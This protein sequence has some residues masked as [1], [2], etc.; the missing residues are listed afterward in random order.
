M[1]K[2]SLRRRGFLR[3]CALG[4]AGAAV[5]ACQQALP[6]NA[7]QTE[8]A[9]TLSPSPT[10][11]LA[12][13]P[14]PAPQVKVSVA[15]ADQDAWT[16]VKPVK[17]V[18][19]EPHECEG[20]VV[21]VDGREYEA[22][23][24]GD[25]FTAEVRLAEGEN[26][27]SA[28][29]RREGG[30]EVR[31]EPVNFTGRLREVPTAVIQMRLEEGKIILDGGESA[32]FDG[33]PFDGAPSGGSETGEGAAIVDHLWSARAGN[34][35]PLQIEGVQGL[36]GRELTGEVSSPSITVVPPAV[37]GEYY[38]RLR[39]IDQAGQ[40]DS[41]EV[42][43]VVEA[44]QPR[45][46]D[47]ETEG[48]AWAEE[49]VVYGVIPFLFGSPAF[50]A[51]TDRLDDLA[52]LGINTLWLGPINVHPGDDYGY[53]VEDYFDL[54]PAYGTKEDFHRLVQA[55][56]ARGIRVMM[57]FVPNHTSNTH[58][59]FLDAEKN[60]EESPYWDYYDRDAAGQPTHYFEW[61]HLPNLNY[62]NPEVRRMMLE[63]FS[64]WV[65][66][67]DVDGFRVD[68]AWGIQ[69]RYP[70][71]WPEWRRELK[72]IKADLLLL[73]EASAREPDYFENGFDAAYDWTYQIGGWAWRVIWDTY[74]YRLLAYNLTDALTNRPE[75]FHPDARIFRF[76][77]NND[78]G[79]RFIT[80]HGEGVT[81]VATALLLTLP[82]IPLIYTGD[83]YGLE[84]EPYQELT[85]L[86]FQERYP[87]LRA[88]HKK[89]I[90]LRKSLPNLQSRY[91]TQLEH[92][93][94]PQT[95]YGYFRHGAPGGR[96]PAVEAENDSPVLVLLNFSEEPA[97]IV[98]DLPEQFAALAQGG[99]LYDLLND[100][101]VSISASGRQ[102]VS[103]PGWTA[104][105]LAN[106]P[107]G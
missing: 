101:T 37:D 93:P 29:C 61:E 43:F 7:L 56:H 13:S 74:R 35:A 46:P 31:S 45:I 40:E 17:A 75:G 22:Q 68:V 88:Y 44:G 16:W 5:A 39:V 78:T 63:A 55:A 38:L 102:T 86:T 2:A 99:V 105:I 67:F 36:E 47:F 42:Y 96:E 94:V 48:P 106:Q 12:P 80:T 26:Q 60:G 20:V 64:Y 72:R 66:E 53:A 85:P 19:S 4:A 24:E 18:V 103:V 54:D 97:E 32:P 11:T 59:Y 9:A 50:Q 28:A 15:A 52:E 27:V 83:E 21:Y 33:A 91:W 8:G 69:E 51:I 100:E 23:P 71:F 3:L 65:R 73:A 76:L 87:G 41:S 98:F 81:R 104:R 92:D 49:A 82:G 1:A 62:D 90:A 70:E 79:E 57:D 77:N 10:P 95:V 58:P 84:F 14:T 30:V 6:D 107:A 25:F 34:P 89:L